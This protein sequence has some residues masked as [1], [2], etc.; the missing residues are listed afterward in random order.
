MV[1]CRLLPCLG[2]LVRVYGTCVRMCVSAYVPLHFFMHDSLLNLDP[3]DGLTD[4][5]TDRSRP[6]QAF[7]LPPRNLSPSLTHSLSVNEWS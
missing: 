6:V 1:F 2:R 4:G 3:I 5:R 7:F